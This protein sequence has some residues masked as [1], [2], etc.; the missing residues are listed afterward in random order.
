MHLEVYCTVDNCHYWGANNHCH[1]S[2]ILITSDSFANSAPDQIDAFQG[3][4]LAA[5]PVRQCMETACKTFVPKD[6]PQKTLMADQVT[7]H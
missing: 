2:K 7:Y 1:A 6:A 5:T 3:S 4:T